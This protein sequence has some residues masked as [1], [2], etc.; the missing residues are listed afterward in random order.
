[1][2][3]AKLLVVG[4]GSVGRRHARNFYSLGA[5]VGCVDPRPDRRAQIRV[6]LPGIGAVY[7][8]I[9]EALAEAGDYTGVV[10]ASPP[11]F[12]VEQAMAFLQRGIPVL[13]EKPVSPDL[14]SARQL[15][16]LS[17]HV[18]APLM[19]GYTYRWWPPFL[20][21][22]RRLAEQILG[23]PRRAQLVMSAH[24]ADWHPWER[25][26]EFFMASRELGGGALLDESHFIDLMVWLFGMPQALWGRV[27]HL[28]ELEIDTDDNV[29]V[30]ALYPD[31]F[32]V[33]IHLD[34]Y[35]RPH[36]KSVSVVG[37]R[38]TLKCLF[39]PNELRFSSD[40]EGNWEVDSFACERND[41]FVALAREFLDVLCGQQAPSCTVHDGVQVLRCVE[42]A[43]K[44]TREERTVRLAEIGS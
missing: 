41:M 12:H 4:A 30:L 11:R 17:K 31:N 6:E 9:A 28:S 37:E 13:L 38:G 25:Y 32:R 19:L 29:E 35:G 1:V 10:I 8:D 2:F 34:L 39:D 43:R 23:P 44:A 42:A 40:A 18:Q 20:E 15:E 3:P 26:Q 24:L 21:L 7:A 5:Q 16:E 33:S 14:A 22:R 27:E 36:E